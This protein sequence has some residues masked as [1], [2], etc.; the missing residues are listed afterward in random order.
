MS[1]RS[2][3]KRASGQDVYLCHACNDCDLQDSRAMD[4]PLSSLV[5]LILLDDEEALQSRT[6][7]SDAVLEA[8]RGACKRGLDLRAVMLVLRDEARRR[9]EANA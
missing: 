6:L 1:L 3:V 2:I 8:A 4:I 5:Q 9:L 7:W